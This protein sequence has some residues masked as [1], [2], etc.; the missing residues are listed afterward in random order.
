MHTKYLQQLRSQGTCCVHW[1]K[2]SCTATT[3]HSTQRYAYAW[4]NINSSLP[5]F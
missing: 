1:A 2:W 3:S 5:T 4:S